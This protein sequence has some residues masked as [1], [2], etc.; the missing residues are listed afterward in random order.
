MVS[1]RREVLLCLLAAIS[2]SVYE[3]AGSENQWLQQLVISRRKQVL[4]QA[5]FYSLL[6]TALSYD[7]VGW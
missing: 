6:N 3:R 1:K 5:M 2:S 4:K 7:P